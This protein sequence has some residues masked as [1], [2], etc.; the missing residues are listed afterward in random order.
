M[1]NESKIQ[2]LKNKIAMIKEFMK[3]MTPSSS[4]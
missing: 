4:A 2:K 3:G 1:N